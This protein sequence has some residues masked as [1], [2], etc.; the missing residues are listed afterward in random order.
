MSVFNGAD[1]LGLSMES[2]LSQPGVEFEFIIID[3]GSTDRTPE[4]LAEYAGDPRVRIHVQQPN[5]GL[6]KALIQG[7]AMAQG[8]YIARQDVG[9]RTLPGR[10]AEQSKLLAE[11]PEVV[12]ATCWTRMVGP[13]G[14]HLSEIHGS[15]DSHEATRALRSATMGQ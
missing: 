13:G 11:N 14:E 9:D 12:L 10:L 5:Q 1:H 8:A 4:V 3:D 15:S 7:C 6:T 2:V